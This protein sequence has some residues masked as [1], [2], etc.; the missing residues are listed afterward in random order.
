MPCPQQGTILAVQ[1]IKVFVPSPEDHLVAVDQRTG[2][3]ITFY[4][5]ERPDFVSGMNIDCPELSVASS[6]IRRSVTDGY[7]TEYGGRRLYFP[8]LLSF[9]R[10][11]TVDIVVGRTENNHSV[12]NCRCTDN[13][14]FGG[15]LPQQLSIAESDAT[16][17][18]LIVSDI[19][20]VFLQYG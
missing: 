11:H 1:G 19:N 6:E 13:P 3:H 14:H 15:K 17:Q 10:I 18:T 8:Q 12:S 5:I 2:L 4:S 16:E 7:R 20:P 9:F